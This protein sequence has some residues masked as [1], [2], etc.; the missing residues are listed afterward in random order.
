MKELK[1]ISIQLKELL[2]N[3]SKNILVD[4][5]QTNEIINVKYTYNVFKIKK[6]ELM[7]EPIDEEIIERNFI[8]DRSKDMAKLF[9][10]DIHCR[11]ACFVNNYDS[12]DNHCISY[13]HYHIRNNILNSFIYVRS[14]NFDTNFVYDNQTFLLAYF[15]LYNQLQKTYPTLQKGK[16]K[17]FNFSLHKYI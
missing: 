9:I 5:K 17:V 8:M 12:F 13:L 10:D 11:R 6:S 3:D 16:I 15:N 4:K 1:K 7:K 2:Q 14:Q